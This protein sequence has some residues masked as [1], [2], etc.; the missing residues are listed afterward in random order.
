ML[1]KLLSLVS[2]YILH[3]HKCAK[4]QN[5]SLCWIHL[6]CCSAFVVIK[7]LIFFSFHEELL[8]LLFKKIVFL[9]KETDSNMANL[10]PSLFTQRLDNYDKLK[11]KKPEYSAETFWVAGLKLLIMEDANLAAMPEFYVNAIQ[12]RAKA[13]FNLKLLNYKIEVLD[14]S[15]GLGGRRKIWCQ[16]CIPVT[17]IWIQLFKDN[18]WVYFGRNCSPSALTDGH[19]SVINIYLII[20]NIFL[21]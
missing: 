19:W 13:F 5:V 15:S 12:Q 1:W 7:W 4:W 8:W 6:L 11:W 14:F 20:R 9:S 21:K 2:D 16:K 10:S 17:F 3:L 18:A